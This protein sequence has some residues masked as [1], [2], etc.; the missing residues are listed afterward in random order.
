MS[1][2]FRVKLDQVDRRLDLRPNIILMEHLFSGIPTGFVFV[3][4]S[5]VFLGHKMMAK[6]FIQLMRL[7][8]VPH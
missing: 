1:D 8:S 2:D 4:S 5:V 3:A 6:R 7:T